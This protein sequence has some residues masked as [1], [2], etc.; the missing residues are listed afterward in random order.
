MN[1]MNDGFSVEDRAILRATVERFVLEDCPFTAR[2]TALASE[3]GYS[4]SAWR[5]MAGLGLLGLLFEEEYGGAGAGDAELAIVMECVGRGILLEPYLA[6]A[7]LGATL[8]RQLGGDVLRERLLPRIAGGELMVAL[9]H[10]EAAA[11]F[12]RAPV[13]TSV[14]SH[15][16]KLHLAGS[17]SFVLHGPTADLLLVTAREADGLSVFAIPP[18]APNLA[19]TRWRTVDGRWAA[20]IELRKVPVNDSQRLGAPGAAGEALD[21]VL[22]R[23]TL[24]VCAEALGAM[25]VLLDTTK[26]HLKTRCQFGRPLAEFQVLQHRLVDMFIALEETRAMLEFNLPL[27]CASARERSAAV[28]ATKFQAGRAARFVGEQA[29]Q[30]HGAMGMTDELPVSHYFKRLLMIDALFGNVEYQLGRFRESS[31]QAFATGVSPRSS[32][33]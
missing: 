6:T 4:E 11:G 32:R 15:G 13:S 8:V 28:A 22:D 2:G 7:V 21:L 20:E 18:D 26:E 12:S 1:A 33:Q 9:A 27:L 10:G 25:S 30:L 31:A 19:L 24:A 17:K 29:I 14:T 23:A 5:T 16:G 3:R